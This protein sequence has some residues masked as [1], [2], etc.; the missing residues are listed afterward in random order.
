VLHFDLLHVYATLN[1]DHTMA[2]NHTQTERDGH[3]YKTQALAWLKKQ[4]EMAIITKHKHLL[5]K[6]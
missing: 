6:P 5:G 3:H 1:G 2:L 4:K